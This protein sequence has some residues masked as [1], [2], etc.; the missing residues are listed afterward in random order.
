MRICE[1]YVYTNRKYE[2]D[3]NEERLKA[4]EF[5]GLIGFY[6]IGMPHRNKNNIITQEFIR[7]EYIN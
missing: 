3:T 7:K 2:F 1:E 5:L 6:P 4:I